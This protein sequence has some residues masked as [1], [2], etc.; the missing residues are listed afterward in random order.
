MVLHHLLPDEKREALAEI[1]RV[2][3]PGGLLLV[4]DWGRPHDP[5]MSAIFFLSQAVDGFERTGDH[6]AGRIPG[7]LAEAGFADVERY[8]RLRTAF[9]SLDLL[10]ASA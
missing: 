9:G 10:T 7:F 2:L 5:L 3:R 4:A 8:D 1:R 6:R